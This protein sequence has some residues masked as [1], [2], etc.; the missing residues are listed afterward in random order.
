MT[1]LFYIILSGFGKNTANKQSKPDEISFTKM[2][3]ATII[4]STIPLLI[5][6]LYDFIFH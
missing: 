2:L 3:I 1:H 5:Y 4:L 6:I